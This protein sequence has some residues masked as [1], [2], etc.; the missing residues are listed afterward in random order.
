MQNASLE[1]FLSL[2]SAIIP[3]DASH[4]EWRQH[5]DHRGRPR[6]KVRAGAWS[7]VTSRLD[8]ASYQ[9]LLAL[10][11]SATAVVEAHATYRRAD[12]HGTF[13]TVWGRRCTVCHVYEHFDARGTNGQEPGW[14][15]CYDLLLCTLNLFLL[16]GHS[17]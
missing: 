11:L 5:V 14:V 15:L 13:V 3:L 6:S 1:A 8:Q 4:Y 10:M 7:F 2:G 9:H 12:G 17:A 16:H